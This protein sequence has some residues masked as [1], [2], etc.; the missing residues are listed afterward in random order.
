MPSL[1]QID[2]ILTAFTAAMG[3]ITAITGLFAM[4][5]QLRPVAENP[6]PYSMFVMVRQPPLLCLWRPAL[7]HFPWSCLLRG[8][9][10][11]AVQHVA[12]LPAVVAVT[13]AAARL[14]SC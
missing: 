3:L 11:S 6:G 12:V 1:L 7:D 8:K 13:Q 5:V 2:L 4:N 14:P 9:R 10:S